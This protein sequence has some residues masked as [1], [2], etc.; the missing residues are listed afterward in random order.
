MMS[1][2]I[3]LLIAVLKYVCRAWRGGVKFRALALFIVGLQLAGC[4]NHHGAA[5][6]VSEPA[7]ATVINLR[8]K[9]TL[10][11]T[12]LLVHFNEPNNTRQNI[13]LSFAKDGYYKKISSFWLSLGHSSKQAALNNAE[14]WFVPLQKIGE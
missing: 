13:A 10:G 14:E 1:L 12:P 5:S 9:A 3:D 4:A 11:V 6:V 2:S 7:G 8:T